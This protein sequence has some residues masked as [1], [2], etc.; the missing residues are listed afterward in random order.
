MRAKNGSKIILGM[1]VVFGLAVAFSGC[2]GSE[3]GSNPIVGPSP[4][5][6]AGD[7]TLTANVTTNTC[8]MGSPATIT[9]NIRLESD[10]SGLALT[11]TGLGGSCSTYD[12]AQQSGNILT[13]ARTDTLV[14]GSCTLQVQTTSTLS[15]TGSHYNSIEARHYDYYAGS[16]PAFSPCDVVVE[17]QGDLCAGCFPGCVSVPSEGGSGSP[18]PA[19]HLTG[20]EE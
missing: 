15:F 14:Y 17:G 18:R 16:C 13:Q 20:V 7:Y 1:L 19:L 5:T 11:Q 8:G 10:G 6:L 2:G 3:S 4:A 9:G 12:A